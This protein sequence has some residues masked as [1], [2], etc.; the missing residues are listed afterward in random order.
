[1]ITVSSQLSFLESH[2]RGTGIAI[3][4][5]D[6]T[7]I[8]IL[9]LRARLTEMRQAGLVVRSTVLNKYGRRA[10]TV[11]ARDTKGSRARLFVA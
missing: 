3:T 6:A 9:N 11:S 2:L 1:M 5:A 8:G 7:Q 4:S 10:F